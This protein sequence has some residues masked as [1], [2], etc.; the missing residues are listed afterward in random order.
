MANR[1][2]KI[3][4]LWVVFTTLVACSVQNR[5][6]QQARVQDRAGMYDE[7]ANLYYN[8]LLTDGKTKKPS[9]V[10]KATDKK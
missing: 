1:V 7:A 6:L 2:Q 8:V 4:C 5:V 10:Y 3:V 9:L